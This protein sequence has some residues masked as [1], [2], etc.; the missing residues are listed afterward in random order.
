MDLFSKSGLAE[1]M[2]AAT[3]SRA[4]FEL[5]GV[6]SPLTVMR[7]RSRDLSFGCSLRPQLQVLRNQIVGSRVKLA[8]SGPLFTTVTRMKI[9]SKSRFA[10][11]TKRSK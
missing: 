9:S 3:R 11:S 10:Y 6:V 5:K 2:R 1:K 7:I 4:A 8:G